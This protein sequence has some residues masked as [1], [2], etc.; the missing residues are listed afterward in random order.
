MKLGK[1][2]VTRLTDMPKMTIKGVMRQKLSKFLKEGKI[3]NA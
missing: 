2:Q 3:K 1:L